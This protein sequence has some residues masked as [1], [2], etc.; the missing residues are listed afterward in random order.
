MLHRQNLPIMV[1]MVSLDVFKGCQ[2]LCSFFDVIV[3]QDI[4]LHRCCSAIKVLHLVDALQT[5]GGGR[6]W[7]GGC[8]GALGECALQVW[9]RGSASFPWRRDGIIAERVK[10]KAD[11]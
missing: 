2:V 3:V 6:A 4:G 5:S 1:F 7:R 9:G 11:G 8:G 10:A